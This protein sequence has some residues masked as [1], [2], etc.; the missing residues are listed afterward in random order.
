VIPR[1]IHRIWLG[2]DPMPEQ[3]LHYGETWRTH[4]P[5]WEMRLWTEAELPDMGDARAAFDA[6]RNHSE[7][8]NVL[9]YE[10]LRSHGGVYVDTDMECLRPLDPLLEGVTA[11]AAYQRPGRV[12]SSIIGAEAGHPA[13][14]EA[15][16]RVL[17]RTGTGDQTNENGPGFLAEMLAE[18]DDVTLFDKD[19]FYPYTHQELWRASEEFPDAYA[20]HHWSKTWE[21]RED[22]QK[23]VATLQR[24]VRRFKHR[25]QKALARAGRMEERVRALERSPWNRVGRAL[26]ATAGAVRRRIPARARH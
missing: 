19:L 9:R 4:H 23:K 5:G 11:F 7:R 1:I 25:E 26:L 10:L 20:V 18:H 3:F 2:S 21:S 15:V 13:F 16:K 14:E 6:G 12:G 17:G 24:R 22:L 8:S